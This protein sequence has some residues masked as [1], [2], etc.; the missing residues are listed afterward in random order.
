[1][2]ENSLIDTFELDFRSEVS[3]HEVLP[4]GS[5]SRNILRVAFLHV[6]GKTEFLLYFSRR[7][8]RSPSQ[9]RFYGF[10]S[11]TQKRRGWRGLNREDPRVPQREF[12]IVHDL[13]FEEGREKFVQELSERIIVRAL[14][15][16]GQ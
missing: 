12:V 11:R 15:L 9:P 16:R 4:S 8:D 1:M 6:S 10:G 2:G 13:S 7:D 5:I 14:A 3:W